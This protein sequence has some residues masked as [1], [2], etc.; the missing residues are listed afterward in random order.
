MKVK[1][2]VKY[3]AGHSYAKEWEPT[4]HFC[5]GCGTKAVWH[6][7]C[8]GDYY[9]GEDYLCRHC[10]A[11]FTMQYSGPVP[12]NW[13]TQQSLEAIRAAVQSSAGYNMEPK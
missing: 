4:D 13:Q 3:E 5:P 12:K 7:T 1:L 9:V 8:D 10:G 6:E 2:T 11:L